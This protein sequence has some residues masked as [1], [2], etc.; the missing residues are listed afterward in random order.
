M[1]DISTSTWV[2]TAIVFALGCLGALGI[3]IMVVGCVIAKPTKR[4][5]FKSII[6]CR[7]LGAV[8][9]L[10]FITYVVLPVYSAV[11][12]LLTMVGWL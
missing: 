12:L 6:L 2:I 8:I 11:N 9:T 5:P 7:V 1:A 3:L 4:G 10:V